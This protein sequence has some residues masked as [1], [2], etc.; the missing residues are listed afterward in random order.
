[1]VQ[2]FYNLPLPIKKYSLNFGLWINSL[3]TQVLPTTHPQITFYRDLLFILY[4][5]P[6]FPMFHK[7]FQFKQCLSF[8]LFVNFFKFGNFL[9]Y[10]KPAVHFSFFYKIFS[11]FFTYYKIQ[12]S[13]PNLEKILF[14]IALPWSLNRFKTDLVKS[15]RYF[16]LRRSKMLVRL[17]LLL[18][19]SIACGA[20]DHKK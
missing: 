5:L 8:E 10:Q 17:L 13:L 14:V 18:A 3:L 2:F 12:H 7:L 19:R 20:I 6:L 9:Q 1:M 16:I 4:V 11:T 15:W